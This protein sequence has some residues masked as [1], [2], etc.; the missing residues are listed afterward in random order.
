MGA[1]FILLTT[2]GAVLPCMGFLSAA[3]FSHTILWGGAAAGLGPGSGL[4][5]PSEACVMRSVSL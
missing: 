1:R 2:F 4:G 3:P 5:S